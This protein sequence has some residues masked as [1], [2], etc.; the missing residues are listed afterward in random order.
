M[1]GRVRQIRTSMQSA[2]KS[3]RIVELT[4]PQELST[5]QFEDDA[6]PDDGMNHLCEDIHSEINE[7]SRTL[8]IAHGGKLARDQGKLILSL[9]FE[10]CCGAVCHMENSAQVAQGKRSKTHAGAPKKWDKRCDSD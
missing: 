6:H 9:A 2:A 1:G 5:L 8:M 4:S 3:L 7:M 10:S